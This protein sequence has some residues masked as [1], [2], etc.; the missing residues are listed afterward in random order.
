MMF[1]IRHRPYLVTFLFGLSIN[2][3]VVTT[4]PA[5]DHTV[6]EAAKKEG[7]E[8]EAYVTLRTDTARRVWDL[9]EGKYPFLRVKQYKADSEKMLQRLLTEYRAKKYLVDFLNFGGGFQTQVLIE[10]GIAGSYISPET[11]YFAPAFKDKNGLWTTL[12]YNPMTIVY[13]TKLIPAN[14]RPKDWADLLNPRL[15]GKMAMEQ[16]QVTWYAGIMKRFGEE[17]AKHYF[18]ALSKQEFRIEASGRG[19]ALLAAGEFAA[20]VGRGHVA[21]MFKKKGAPVEWIK[22]PDPLVVQPATIQMAKYAPHPNSA[23]LLIDFML[24]ETVAD[25]LAKENRLPG[26]SNVSGLDPAFKEINA[27]KIFP[28]SMEEVQVNYKKYLDEFRNYFGK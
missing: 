15:K 17:K 20:Y 16:E 13:N 27:D 19:N 26:R 5:S 8:I 25:V 10:Q 24:S 6:I 12:Y 11:K 4:V 18:Q 21:E 22:N 7:G 9:F 3:I 2:W 14:E 28:L 23:K 1:P